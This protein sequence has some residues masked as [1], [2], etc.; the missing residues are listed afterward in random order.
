M[1]SWIFH[2]VTGLGVLLFLAAHIVDTMLILFGPK[3][4]NHAVALYRLPVFR[5]GEVLVAAAVLYHG[6]NGIRVILVD[7]LPR[8]TRYH[9]ALFYWV[10]ILFFVFFIPGAYL[11]IKPLFH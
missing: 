1:W 6:L 5:I 7:L 4:Y 3:I 2:R 8:A 9:R 11:M 10:V